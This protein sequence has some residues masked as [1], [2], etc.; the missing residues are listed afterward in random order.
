[1][2]LLAFPVRAGHPTRWRSGAGMSKAKKD[3]FDRG[4]LLAVAN[5]IHLHG[6][7]T[8]VDDLFRQHEQTRYRIEQL[9]FDD[10]DRL[11]LLKLRRRFD[12]WKRL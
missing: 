11:P 7:S 3:A 5:L 9:G 1:V 12:E 6:E 8:E 4:Y 10:Y 2:R